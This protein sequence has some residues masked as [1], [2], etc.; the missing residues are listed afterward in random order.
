MTEIVTEFENDAYFVRS[1]IPEESS[2]VII[3]SFSGVGAPEQHNGSFFGAPLAKSL[4]IAFVGMVARASNYYLG[5]GID[6]AILTA[7]EII[8]RIRATAQ[9]PVTIIGYGLSMGGYAAIKHAR[10]LGLDFVIALAPAF[11]NDPD[12]SSYKD[13]DL[14]AFKESMKGMAPKNAEVTVPCYL[15]YDPYNAYDRTAMEDYCKK[16]PQV[17]PIAVPYAS[18]LVG[19]TLKGSRNFQ[20]ILRTIMEGGDFKALV[21]R[22]RFESVENIFNFLVECSHKNIK[23]LLPA[24]NTHRAHITDS[25]ERFLTSGRAALSSTPRLLE[26]NLHNEA[27]AL[28]RMIRE[29]VFDAPSFTKLLAWTGEFVC[30]DPFEEA[31]NQT[32]WYRFGRRNL[33]VIK[34]EKLFSLTTIGLERLDFT[35]EK[36]GKGFVIGTSDGQY[37]S[38]RPEGTMLLVPWTDHWETFLPFDQI[39]A[40]QPQS[41]EQQMALPVHQSAGDAAQ[42]S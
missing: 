40:Q 22:I 12:E 3:V 7:W 17:T 13:I 20:A 32:S 41:A 19:L 27:M 9:R 30:Y 36:R 16:V 14:N 5:D 23:L 33:V 11:S 34:D 1:F 31:F 35:L 21:R 29:S 6:D 18:H 26:N 4:N 8:E 39:M 15:F 28:F 2:S 24:L 37:V 10:L 25:R 42:R 38:A